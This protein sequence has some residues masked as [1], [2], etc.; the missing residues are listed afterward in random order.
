[1]PSSKVESC[2]KCGTPF[3]KEKVGEYFSWTRVC[4]CTFPET[5]SDINIDIFPC[6]T[7]SDV[8]KKIEKAIEESK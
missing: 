8:G 7:P 2:E 5:K 4:M 3:L 1:M 6:D